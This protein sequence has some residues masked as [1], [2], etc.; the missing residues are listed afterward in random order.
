[1]IS[2]S[3]KPLETSRV[4]LIQQQ[5]QHR[6]RGGVVG[7]GDRGNRLL[8]ID[9]AQAGGP[10]SGD[11]PV[12]LRVEQRRHLGQRHGL[13]PM[14]QPLHSTA[15]ARFT[16]R[17]HQDRGRQHQGADDSEG[18]RLRKV[19]FEAALVGQQVRGDT[20]REDEADP[21]GG[22]LDGLVDPEEHHDTRD[23]NEQ[24][25][26]DD[27]EAILVSM[28]LRDGGWVNIRTARLEEPPPWVGKTLQLLGLLLAV[29]IAGGLLLARRM[30]QP[31]ARLAAASN[32]LGLGQADAHLPEEGP[33]E[34][35]QTIHAFNRMQERLK[36]HIQDRSRMLAAVPHELRT[37]ITTFRLRTEYIDDTECARR[38]SPPWPKW[39]PFCPPRSTSPGT[40]RRRN[41]PFHGPGRPGAK[42][43]RRPR[44]PRRRGG[45]SLT[46]PV[47]LPMPTDVTASRAEQPHRQRPQVRQ[48]RASN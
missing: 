5:P 48:A 39:R 18:Q 4:G 11:D 45:L 13:D 28:R 30:A 10:Y 14:D 12:R 24:T 3:D 33:R 37:P 26:T 44:G 31:M 34:I 1:M 16:A 38:P 35:R 9:H 41:R 7:R 36:R 15:A 8:R 2:A 21:L 17:E 32:R 20:R 25:R 23:G 40:D 46:G 29:V 27:V 22:L 19:T 6:P 43:G 42:R 47:H